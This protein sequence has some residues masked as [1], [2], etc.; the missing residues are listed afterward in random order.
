MAA[1]VNT[2]IHFSKVCMREVAR[3]AMPSLSRRTGEGWGEGLA[4]G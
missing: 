4:L 3:V 2:L 1:L